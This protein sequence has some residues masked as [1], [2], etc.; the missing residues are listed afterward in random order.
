MRRL[1]RA[2]V[3]VTSEK[4]GGA[5]LA[6]FR[7]AVALVMVSTLVSVSVRG[8]VDA[9]WLPVSAGGARPVGSGY[10][11]LALLGG[12]E[13]LTVWLLIGVGIVSGGL[14]AAGFGGRAIIAL[15]VCSYRAVSTIGYGSGSYDAMIFNAGWLLFLGDATATWS[16]DCLRREGKWRSLRKV[17][18]WPRYLLVLQLVIIYTATGLQKTSASWTFADDYSALYWFMQDPT[19]IRFGSTSDWVAAAYPVT[20]AMTFVVW[21]FEVGAPLLLIVYYLRWTSHRGG[22]LRRWVLRHDPRRLFTAVGLGMHLGIALLMDMGP[23]SYISAAYYLCLWRPEEIEAFAASVPVA[24]R[25]TGRTAASASS[26]A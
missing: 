19:W 20:Q 9:L 7:M 21:H 4:E 18:A 12:P 6:A 13:P 25:A 1:W 26:S 8:V 16:V 23:F 17:S 10:F 15:A 14:M 5:T 3:A 24:V 11:V 2:W 22:R